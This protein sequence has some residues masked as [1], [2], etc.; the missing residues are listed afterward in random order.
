[1]FY[2]CHE[3]IFLLQLTRCL[4]EPGIPG[5]RV[6]NSETGT[7]YTRF[8]KWGSLDYILPSKYM[9]TRVKIT[10]KIVSSYSLFNILTIN[11]LFEMYKAEFDQGNEF[12]PTNVI[13]DRRRIS[14]RACA[15]RRKAEIRDFRFRSTS[16][17]H[18]YRVTFCLFEAAKNP[19]VNTVSCTA[20]VAHARF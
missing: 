18:L 11:L 8:P 1:M 3:L 17:R 16:L 2:F 12:E 13:H 14:Y 10:N 15:R 4:R 6:A 5:P 20:A 19:L 7:G 9:F